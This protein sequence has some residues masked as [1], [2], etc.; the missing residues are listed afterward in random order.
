MK[1]LAPDQVGALLRPG[2]KVAVFGGASEPRGIAA[3]LHALPE[4]TAGVEFTVT[5]IPGISSPTLAPWAGSTVRSFFVTPEMRAGFEAGAVRFVPMQYRHIWDHLLAEPFELAIAQFT[6]PDRNGDCSLGIGAGF[7]PA[8]LGR[9]EISIVAEWNRALPRLPAAPTVRADRFDYVVETEVEPPT[10]AS[11]PGAVT[12]RI[13]ALVAELVRDGDCIET[14]VG[15]IPG[16]VLAALRGHRDLGFHSGLLSDGVVDLVEA[17]VLNG[18]RKSI[19]RGRL[20]AAMVLGSPALYDWA[21]RSD[22]IELRG[23][24]Y[25][26]DVR[27]IAELDNFV[28][29]NSAVE[30]DLFGQIN[31]EMVRGRQISGTGGAVDFMRGARMSRGGRSIVAFEATAGDGRFSRIVPA[32]P[33]GNAA[34]AL[35]TDADIFVTEYGVAKIRGVDVMERARRLIRIAAPKFRE[36][37]EAQAGLSLAGELNEIGRRGGKLQVRDRRSADEILGYDESGLPR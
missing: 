4:A 8:L 1:K 6:P 2:M 13:G 7:L 34:T 10:L 19:D 36:E 28:A 20:V 29:L 30:V 11:R 15:A 27:V 22:L 25:T 17:G 12:E 9:P 14:G 5:R 23:A 37:L 16:A 33:I 18:A 32:L 24:N 21:S 3:A 35:R 31:S 26:H